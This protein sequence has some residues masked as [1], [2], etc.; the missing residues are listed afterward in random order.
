MQLH[1]FDQLTLTELQDLTNKTGKC[2]V[3]VVERKKIYQS[4][5]DKTIIYYSGLIYVMPEGKT[6]VGS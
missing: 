6:N 1:E 4:R 5:N 2:L 3:E